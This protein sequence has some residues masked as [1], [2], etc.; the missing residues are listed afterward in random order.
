VSIIGQRVSV[1][2]LTKTILIDKP[3]YGVDGGVTFS[4]GEPMFQFPFALSLAKRLKKEGVH[5]CMETSGYAPVKNFKEIAP[6]ID[7]VLFDYKATSPSEHEKFTGVDNKL[8]LE[9]LDYLYSTGCEIILRCPLIQGVNDSQD[10]LR[11]IARLNMRY[12]NLQGVEVMAYHNLGISKS[13][14]IG[15]PSLINVKTSD[16][17]Q[18]RTW[19]HELHRLGCKKGEIG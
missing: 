3:Y 9:N 8:I 13:E 11:G 1:E 12:P 5:I 19:I 15:Q 4:G 2:Q 7:L 6:L 16:E 18:K 14:Q 17:E 10:H